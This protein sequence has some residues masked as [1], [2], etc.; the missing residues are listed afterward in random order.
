MDSNGSEL[1]VLDTPYGTPREKKGKED[2]KIEGHAG[3]RCYYP[4]NGEGEAGEEHG[5]KPSLQEGLV[6]W[7]Y[8][9]FDTLGQ[10]SR[11]VHV[12]VMCL[13]KHSAITAKNM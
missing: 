11:C 8:E 9:R 13:C 1:P 7:V 4:R 5:R 3:G 2:E 10:G 6:P 12:N